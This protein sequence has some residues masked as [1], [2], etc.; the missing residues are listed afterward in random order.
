MQPRCHLAAVSVIF[1][2]SGAKCISFGLKSFLGVNLV[3][4][5]VRADSLFEAGSTFSSYSSL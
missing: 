3:V 1:I 2:F 4:V 5:E